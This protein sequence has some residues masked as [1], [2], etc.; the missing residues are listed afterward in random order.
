MWEWANEGKVRILRAAGMLEGNVALL[1]LTARRLILA[2]GQVI[3]FCLQ[4]FV[5][6]SR[7]LPKE[8]KLGSR[9]SKTEPGSTDDRPKAYHHLVG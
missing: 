7:L 4:G 8:E 5:P 1:I 6:V 2:K 3:R 9:A